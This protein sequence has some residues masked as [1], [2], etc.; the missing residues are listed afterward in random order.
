MHSIHFSLDHRRSMTQ[1]KLHTL[2]SQIRFFCLLVLDCWSCLPFRPRDLPFCVV[3][4]GVLATSFAFCFNTFNFR[5]WPVS[6]H[7]AYSAFRRS[8]YSCTDEY[9]IRK[10]LSHKTCFPRSCFWK[11]AYSFEAVLEKTSV[12][13]NLQC[14]VSFHFPITT[15]MRL[16]TCMIKY[17][18]RHCI[19]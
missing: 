9:L 4:T 11:W 12:T 16:Q 13:R 2:E 15:Q 19:A 17:L 1:Y 18:P 8:F 5:F 6:F 3:L 14:S 7:W 10:L